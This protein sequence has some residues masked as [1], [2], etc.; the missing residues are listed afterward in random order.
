MTVFEKSSPIPGPG[1]YSDDFKIMFK[2]VPSWKV[3]TST[4]DVEDKMNARTCAV[5]S[6]V[7]YSPDFNKSKSTLPKWGFGTG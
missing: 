4:R 6:P 7:A 5:P 2:S 3:G 1:T